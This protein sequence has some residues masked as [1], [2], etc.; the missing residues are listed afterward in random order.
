M[1]FAWVLVASTASCE[2]AFGHG[3]GQARG[4]HL[5]PLGSL[6]ATAIAEG[7]RRS[8]TFVELV[9]TVEASDFVVYVQ[10]SRQLKRGM[11]G[12]LVHGDIGLRYLRVVLKTGLSLEKRIEVLAHELQHVREVIEA[13]ILNDPVAMDRLFARVGFTK[14][15]SGAR[16][17]EYETAAALQVSAMVARELQL[18]R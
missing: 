8:P 1:L 17:Q 11:A 10:T 18:R 6:A 5:R 9:E 14:R 2:G 4:P 12:C 13:G 7:V 16:Q 3:G 15:D